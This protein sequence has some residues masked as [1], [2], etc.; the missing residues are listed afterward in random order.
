LRIILF[1]IIIS[2]ST[3]FSQ[4]D[5]VKWEKA[6]HSYIKPNE[7][8]HRDY[9]FEADD[10]GEALVK[11]IGNAYWFFISDLDGDNCPFRP[12]C[13]SFLIQSAKKTNLLQGMLM[14]F[15]RFTRDMNIYKGHNHYPRVNKGYYYDPILLYTLDEDNI[16]Y[17]SPSVIVKD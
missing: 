6:E 12:S 1:F 7:Y 3:A 8:R 4:T 15:D 10:I 9:S 11:S 16:D 14:F 5:W 13:S 2:F 17:I